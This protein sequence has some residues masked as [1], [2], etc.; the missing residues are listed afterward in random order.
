MDC[1][2]A[3]AM[4]RKEHGPGFSVMPGL[5]PGIHVLLSGGAKD[6]GGR[7]KPGHDDERLVVPMLRQH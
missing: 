7:D 1:F 4:T 3:L 6:A 5:V 2:A